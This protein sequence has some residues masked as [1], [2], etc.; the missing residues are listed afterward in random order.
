MEEFPA[1]KVHLQP[2]TSLT[3]K[4]P[5]RRMCGHLAKFR[6]SVVV[7]MPNITKNH[8]I[9]YTNFHLGPAKLKKKRK[10]NNYGNNTCNLILMKDY[11]VRI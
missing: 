10:G 4:F 1:S 6:Y 7:F 11:V 9:T 8:A 2:A 5:S 3:G